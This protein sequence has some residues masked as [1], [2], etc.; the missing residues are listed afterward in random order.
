MRIFACF[1]NFNQKICINVI[2]CN[3][4]IFFMCI[5]ETFY[6]LKKIISS[7]GSLGPNNLFFAELF[8]RRFWPKFWPKMPFFSK[9][10]FLTCPNFAFFEL[11]RVENIPQGWF[12]NVYE[13]LIFLGFWPF[14][15]GRILFESFLVILSFKKIQMTKNEKKCHFLWVTLNQGV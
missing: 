5:P 11:A 12:R 9:T 8:L 7:L 6:C 2:R 13:T 14:Q 1:P 4:L 10:N 15:P 3:S